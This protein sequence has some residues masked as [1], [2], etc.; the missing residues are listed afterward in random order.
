M[1]AHSDT[2]RPDQRFPGTTQQL[3]CR[4]LRTRILSGRHAGGDRINPSTV[5][6]ELGISAMPAR[7][8]R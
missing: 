4:F 6:E 8:D 1:Q 7:S 2:M 3:A 5:A